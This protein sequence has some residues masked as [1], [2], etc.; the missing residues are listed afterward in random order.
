MKSSDNKND[1]LFEFALG[2]ELSLLA[3]PNG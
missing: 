1:A 3:G 2:K